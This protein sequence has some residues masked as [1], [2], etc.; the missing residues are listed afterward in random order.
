MEM[1]KTDIILIC[2][3]H[4]TKRGVQMGIEGGIKN[5]TFP[6]I[7]KKCRWLGDVLNKWSNF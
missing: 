2:K 6:C 5:T 3:N 7:L 1:N 4:T